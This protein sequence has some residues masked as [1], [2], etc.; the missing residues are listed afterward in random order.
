MQINWKL[1]LSLVV[2]V[3]ALAFAGGRARRFFH[4]GT[5]EWMN[6]QQ[7]TSP[8][9]PR[10]V[11]DL[12]RDFQRE[13]ESAAQFAGT[14][15]GSLQLLEVLPDGKTLRHWQPQSFTN[16]GFNSLSQFE[17]NR[18][19]ADDRLVGYYTTNGQPLTFT[20]KQ[21]PARSNIVFCTV[22]APEPV[23][24]GETFHA[25]RV[26]RRPEKMKTTA[27]GDYRLALPR[28]FRNTNSVH[29]VAVVLPADMKLVKS[30]PADW[31]YEAGKDGVLVG[32]LNTRLPD[33]A[34]T[35]QVIF[36]EK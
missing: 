30:I 6:Y 3:A 1:A 29:A 4:D 35:P 11:L 32:W 20:L 5:P 34:A 15:V 33:D 2:V 23:A 9:L 16:P 22:I 10:R 24:P 36:R 31:A 27:K 7:L 13:A 25:L 12:Y 14:K 17:V 21:H 19:L 18:W 8:P 26:E 28:P